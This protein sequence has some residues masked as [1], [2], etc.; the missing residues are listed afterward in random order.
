MTGRYPQ[1]P[2]LI[3]MLPGL[4]AKRLGEIELGRLVL[5]G[6]SPDA[7]AS[8]GIAIRADALSRTGDITEGVVRLGG[9]TPRFE[10]HALDENLVA[11]DV[12]YV[13]EPDLA[14]TAARPA[15]IGD[16]VV[17]SA[18]GAVGIVISGPWH[19]LGLLDVASAVARP[20]APATADSS[21]LTLA[22]QLVECE[23]RRKVLFT[24]SDKS[25][26]DP[27][28]HDASERA[29]DELPRYLRDR[30]NRGAPRYAGDEDD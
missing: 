2:P 14:S 25:R 3:E 9:G 28:P 15:Q 22:W 7:L 5:L 30:H 6:N 17:S 19:G 29:D 10:R 1:R 13:L 4:K 27:L 11:I 18:G 20:F 21:Q 24:R 12:E 16:L 26:R 23:A 8:A